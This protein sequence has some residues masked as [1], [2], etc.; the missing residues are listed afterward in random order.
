MWGAGSRDARVVRRVVRRVRGVGREEDVCGCG[1]GGGI[2]KGEGG[3]AGV[4]L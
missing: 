2:G 1:C 4:G 3:G